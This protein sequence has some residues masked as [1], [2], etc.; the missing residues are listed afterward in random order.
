LILDDGAP[1]AEALIPA[2]SRI[3]YARCSRPGSLGAKRNLACEMACGEYI[4]HWDD[5]DW[6]HP[7]RLAL[8]LAGNP[9]VTGFRQMLFWDETTKR[10]LLYRGS[11]MYVLGTSLLFRRTW[12]EANRFR[13]IDVGEDN[14]F[15][16]AAARAG[17]LKPMEGQG[18]MVATNHAHGTS[19]RALGRNWC[20]TVRTAIPPAYWIEE[21]RAS[22]T[23][24]GV[25]L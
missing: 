9:V 7:D 5:D 12:W 19:P 6:S 1:G 21:K 16:R 8:Q 24:P 15:V 13:P 10:A 25:E 23:A 4:A 3:R 17:V 22:M 11:P 2:D 14:A 18:L 20:P